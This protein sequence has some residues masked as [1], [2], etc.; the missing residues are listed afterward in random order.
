MSE[1]DKQLLMLAAKAVGYKINESD[2]LKWLRVSDHDGDWQWNPL[3]DDGDAIRLA[4]KL[5]L[6]I[7]FYF[8]S[9]FGIHN[10]VGVYSHHQK[11]HIKEGMK[12]NSDELAIVRRAIVC[13]SAE[14]GRKM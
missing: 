11:H 10:E 2:S 5:H 3:V 14:I 4:V 12:I 1:E 8:D 7:A 6:D 9:R 13:V